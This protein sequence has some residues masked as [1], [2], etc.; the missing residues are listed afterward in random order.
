[1]SVANLFVQ[2]F[3]FVESAEDNKG[4]VRVVF[5]F[6]LVDDVALGCYFPAR[7]GGPLP[8]FFESCFALESES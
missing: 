7:D 4:G 2:V 5:G 6:D 8:H 3:E 1:M